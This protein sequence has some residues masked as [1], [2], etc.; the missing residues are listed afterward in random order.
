[1][2]EVQVVALKLA[3]ALS[4]AD[5]TKNNK[6]TIASSFWKRKGLLGLDNNCFKRVRRSVS[7]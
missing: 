2:S 7:L 1:M 4:G 6:W 3:F 5:P